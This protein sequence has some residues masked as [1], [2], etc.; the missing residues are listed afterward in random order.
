MVARPSG[1]ARTAASGQHFL[2][3]PDVVSRLVGEARVKPG[4]LVLDLGAGEGAL[5]NEVAR[6]GARV[7]AIELDPRLASFLRRRF[8]RQRMVAILERDLRRLQTPSEEFKVVANL[9][10]QVTTLVLRK[11]LDPSEGMSRAALLVERGVAMKRTR[12]TGNMFNAL[13]FPWFQISEGETVARS[14]FKPVSPVQVSVLRIVRREIPLVPSSH[15]A[16]YEELVRLAFAGSQTPLS[17]SLVQLHGRKQV[18]EILRSV[19]LP[20]EATA[21]SLRAERFAEIHSRLVAMQAEPRRCPPGSS[22]AKPAFHPPRGR[23]SRRGRP[24]RP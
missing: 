23:G 11:L 18:E 10:F 1:R 21:V 3:S 12:R 9:P 8:A 19:G 7:I 22:Q 17:R 13:V 16:S 5:T 4:D 20:L 15:R 2:K 24:R 6:L 14:A